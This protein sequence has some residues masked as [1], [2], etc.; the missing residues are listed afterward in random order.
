MK[1]LVTKEFEKQTKT[2]KDMG[3]GF[4]IFGSKHLTNASISTTNEID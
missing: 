3:N 4:I 1:Q 2:I